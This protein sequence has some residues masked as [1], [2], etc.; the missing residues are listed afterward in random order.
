MRR[1]RLAAPKI[2]ED[3]ALP[4]HMRFIPSIIECHRPMEGESPDEPL[5]QRFA[6]EKRQRCVTTPAKW[7][8][9][10]WL[11]SGGA[12]IAPCR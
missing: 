6:H 4:L 5:A 9:T 2:A 1:R 8:R 7:G 11:D 10:G 3:F 12:A